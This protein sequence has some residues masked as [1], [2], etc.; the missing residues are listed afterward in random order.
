MARKAGHKEG[1]GAQGQGP[2]ERWR[3]AGDPAAS[4]CVILGNA[5]TL[6]GPYPECTKGQ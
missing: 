3:S 2:T 6:S 1:Q 4:R 5:L